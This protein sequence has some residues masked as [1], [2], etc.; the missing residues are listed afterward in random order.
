VV[1]LVVAVVHLPV[2]LVAVVVVRVVVTTVAVVPVATVVVLVV[3]V[4]VRAQALLN[5]KFLIILN[6]VLKPLIWGFK[7]KMRFSHRNFKI[8]L[9]DIQ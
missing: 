7:H 9:K 5:A 3:A 6:T 8:N 2:V 4:V 1:A